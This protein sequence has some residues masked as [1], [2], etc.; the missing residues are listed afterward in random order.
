MKDN[1][2]GL[3]RE[4][5]RIVVRGGDKVECCNTAMEYSPGGLMGRPFFTVF[6]ESCLT[7]Y[8]ERSTSSGLIDF[9]QNEGRIGP[10]PSV[11]RHASVPR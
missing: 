10:R 11:R 9:L 1:V 4:G 2:V 7:L 8:V 3:V 6:C 5:L